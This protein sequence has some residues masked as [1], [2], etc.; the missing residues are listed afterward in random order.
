MRS[1]TI[2]LPFIVERI[3]NADV[4]AD[5]SAVEDIARTSFSDGGFSV[6]EEIARPWS[7]IWVARPDAA[8]PEVPIAFLVAWHVADE[9]HVLNIATEP[10]MRRRGIAR[11]LMD[12]ALEYARDARIRIVLLEVR[13]SNRAAIKLY[14][15]LGFTA[16]GVRPGYYADNDEDAI[17]MMLALD[18]NTGRILPGRDEI[19]IDG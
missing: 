10:A 1:R 5:L 14:R 4:A 3:T 19:R 16:M 2:A 18:P 7:R 8:P 11:L 9:L 17:E 12:V 15:G 13:R 6:A